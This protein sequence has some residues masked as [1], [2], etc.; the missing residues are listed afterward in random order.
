M[1]NERKADLLQL[2]ISF[3]PNCG[4]SEG[5]EQ[6]NRMLHDPTRLARGTTVR[7]M[8]SPFLEKSELT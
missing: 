4:V 6:S 7:V 2:S 3:I 8:R 5:M 1:N